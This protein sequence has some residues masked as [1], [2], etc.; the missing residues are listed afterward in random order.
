MLAE[1]ISLLELDGDQPPWDGEPRM[2]RAKLKHNRETFRVNVTDLK[3]LDNQIMVNIEYQQCNCDKK[4]PDKS[5]GF[6]NR[7]VKVE[8]LCEFVV[9][10]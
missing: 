2:I 6:R 10:Y 3:T 4:E 5:N 1:W 8:C 9:T 7:W